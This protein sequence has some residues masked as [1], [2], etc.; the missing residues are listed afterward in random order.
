MY[1]QWCLIICRVLLEGGADPNIL[2]DDGERPYDLIEPND[3]DTVGV[4][5]SYRA[6]REG[7]NEEDE[8]E[9]EE[10]EE[11]DDRE[12][13]REGSEEEENESETEHVE[14]ESKTENGENESETE[15]VENESETA[16]NDNVD[17]DDSESDDVSC[18]E[19]SLEEAEN[20]SDCVQGIS[21]RLN[22]GKPKQDVNKNHEDLP[23][24]KSILKQSDKQRKT[25]KF[26]T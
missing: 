8:E 20:D 21:L 18:D 23:P 15:N 4:M 24:L 12:E 14:N 6:M 22:G 1:F 3:L 2:T 9:E 5:L 10:D 26:E 17:K 11:E 13:E 7:F 25:L 19:D 16:G